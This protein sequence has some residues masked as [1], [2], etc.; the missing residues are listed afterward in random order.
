MTDTIQSMLKGMARSA[1]RVTADGEGEQSV[2]ATR[3]GGCPDVPADFQWPWFRGKDAYGDDYTAPLTFLG[4]FHCGDLAPLDL[5]HLLPTHGVLSFFYEADRQPWGFRPTDQGSGR[6][7]WFPEEA[8]LQPVDPPAALPEQL[9]LDPCGVSLRQ[10]STC[11]DW[12]DLNLPGEYFDAYEQAIANWPVPKEEGIQ[13]LGWPMTIQSSMPAEVELL[14]NGYDTGNPRKIPP[15]AW[16]QARAIGPER[17]QLLLQFSPPEE[18]TD[19]MFG[20]CGMIYFW[21]TKEDLAARNF[22]R[23][24]VVLQCT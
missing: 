17:W 20:D 14:A 7:Y 11:P 21:I 23:V 4:Q 18:W 24:W 5:E 8:G 19:L 3:L 13:L 16:E 9:H 2:G 6:V 10:V 1:I 22:D 12:E 15:K